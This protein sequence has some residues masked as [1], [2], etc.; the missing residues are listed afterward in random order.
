MSDKIICKII[1]HEN[2]DSNGAVAEFATVRDAIRYIH[3]VRTG[4][5]IDECQDC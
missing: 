5:N 3:Y 4:R 1:D 2:T